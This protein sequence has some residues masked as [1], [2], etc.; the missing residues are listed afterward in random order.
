[1]D[2]RHRKGSPTWLQFYL[3]PGLPLIPS[4][5]LQNLRVEASH[6]DTVGKPQN[7]LETLRGETSLEANV[8]SLSQILPVGESRGGG[9]WAPTPLSFLQGTF[10]HTLHRVLA[11]WFGMEGWR[12]LE[13]QRGKPL[14]R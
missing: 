4:S 8:V 9:P 10:S 11:V 13:R 7:V 2:R 5:G 3:A 6:I 1:M 12:C 14:G